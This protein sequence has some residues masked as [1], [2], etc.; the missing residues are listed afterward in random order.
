MFPWYKI[1]KTLAGTHFMRKNYWQLYFQEVVS[2]TLQAIRGPCSELKVY[3]HHKILVKPVI[4]SIQDLRVR[5]TDSYLDRVV[6]KSH[7]IRACGMI[8]IV[9]DFFGKHSLPKE[10]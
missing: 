2:E 5:E 9:V 10:F 4:V 6:A 3:F 8:Y 1:F 7:C